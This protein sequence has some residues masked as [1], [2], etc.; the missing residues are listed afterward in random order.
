MDKVK[1]LDMY[2]V[3][4]V[5]CVQMLNDIQKQYE[6]KLVT[7]WESVY[8]K[9]QLTL[10]I[11]LALKTH[12]MSM[13]DIK[14]FIEQKTAS[15]ITA[16]DRS[17][18]RALRRFHAM[19]LVSYYDSPSNRGGPDRKIYQL[20]ETGRNVLASFMQRNILAVYFNPDNQNL[21]QGK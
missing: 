4:S 15:A 7:A 8:K 16:D 18:Y 3:G 17:M 20:T 13:A 19:D 9:G 11:L 5:L 12:E 6:T 1:T 10:W 21:L 14:T 2:T